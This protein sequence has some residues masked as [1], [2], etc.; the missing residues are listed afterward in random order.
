MLELVG[1]NF[2]PNLTVWFGDIEAET[3]YRCQTSLVC[4]VPDISLFKTDNESWHSKNINQQTQV[5]IC[6]VRYDGVIF[7]TGLSF[8]YTPEP[9]NNNNNNNNNMEFSTN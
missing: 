1:E 5:T 7:N 4:T 3:A 6:L 9:C 8:T 2:T